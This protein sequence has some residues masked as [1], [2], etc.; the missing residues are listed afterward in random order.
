[1]RLLLDKGAD[2][3]ASSDVSYINMKTESDSADDS[4]Q[5]I[6]CVVNAGLQL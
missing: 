2:I 1:V 4:R 6:E 3:E 5:I